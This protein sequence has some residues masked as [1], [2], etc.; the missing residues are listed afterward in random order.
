VGRR[1]M[2]AEEGVAGLQAGPSHLPP[3]S[4]PLTSLLLA[5]PRLRSGGLTQLAALHHAGV[6][7]VRRQLGLWRRGGCEWGAGA[8]AA[9]SARPRA[10]TLCPP[11]PPIPPPQKA[12]MSRILAA[13]HA[14]ALSAMRALTAQAASQEAQLAAQARGGGQGRVV[15]RSRLRL[16]CS[17]VR[18]GLPFA[19]ATAPS[20]LTAPS[21]P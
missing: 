6:F 18:V 20:F 13:A 12:H 4:L 10:V 19:A 3:T 5:S 15:T 14:P 21:L 8:G 7:V 2:A 17:R 9:P 16:F 1:L 11:P